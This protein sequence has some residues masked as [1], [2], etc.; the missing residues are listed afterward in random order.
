MAFGFPMNVYLNSHRLF[1]LS[2]TTKYKLRPSRNLQFFS[3]LGV[4]WHLVSVKLTGTL[5]FSDSERFRKNKLPQ[6]L[7]LFIPLDKHL[8]EPVQTKVI[9]KLPIDDRFLRACLP[10][11]KKLSSL[12]RNP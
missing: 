11:L 8:L 1:P 3:F 10:Q 9:Q 6:M 2:G 5:L 4:L 12:T 7:P